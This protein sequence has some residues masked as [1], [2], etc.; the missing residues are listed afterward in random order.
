MVLMVKRNWHV[1]L[2][3]LILNKKNVSWEII[4]NDSRS[5]PYKILTQILF[6][7]I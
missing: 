4:A 6:E 7:I 1:V 5:F 3:K 2:A